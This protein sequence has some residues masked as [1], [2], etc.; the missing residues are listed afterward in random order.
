MDN[1]GEAVGFSWIIALIFL[2][3][4]GLGFI[5]FNQTLTVHIEPTSDGLIDNSPYLNASEK[6]DIKDNNDKY[7]AFWN[8][9]PY[10]LT[11]ILVIFTIVAAYRKGGGG[12]Y[13]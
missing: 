10:I 9:L 2:F 4:L 3:I 13:G 5:V 8:T 6:N 12:M 7:M 1:K 11:F